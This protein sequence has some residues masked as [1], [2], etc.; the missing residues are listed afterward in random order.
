MV[1]MIRMMMVNVLVMMIKIMM[2]NVLVTMM[3]ISVVSSSAVGYLL[4]PD[5]DSRL[6]KI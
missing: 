3:M 2:V 4:F 1:M 5:Q 6:I